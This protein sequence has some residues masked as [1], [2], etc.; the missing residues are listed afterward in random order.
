MY[1]RLALQPSSFLIGLLVAVVA[2]LLMSQAKAP[3][4]PQSGAEISS[5]ITTTQVTVVD[6]QRKERLIL[7][8][9]PEGDGNRFGVSL[10]DAA[11][12]ERIRLACSEEYGPEVTMFDASGHVRFMVETVRK[13]SVSLNL[14]G[15]SGEGVAS[16]VVKDQEDGCN[17]Y[18]LVRDS[19]GKY[20]CTVPSSIADGK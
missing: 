19:H 2:F 17:G 14:C 5:P 12:N 16:L 9:L 4:T 11:G 10:R 20:L 18:L 8:T 3:P 7:G 13:D 15:T 1:T 6:S